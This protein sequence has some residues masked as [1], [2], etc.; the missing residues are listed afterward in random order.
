LASIEAP[1][2]ALAPGRFSMITGCPSASASGSAKMR[3]MVS[4][5]APAT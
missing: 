5:E 2:I 4:Y 1:I 3:M